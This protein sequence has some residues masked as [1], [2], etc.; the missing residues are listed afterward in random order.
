MKDKVEG[1]SLPQRTLT[2]TEKYPGEQAQ[3]ADEQQ[4]CYGPNGGK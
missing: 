1:T 3:K 2:D 4:M